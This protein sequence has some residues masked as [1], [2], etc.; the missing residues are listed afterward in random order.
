MQILLCAATEFEVS[1]TKEFIKKNGLENT[2]QLLITGVGMIA[3]TYAITKGVFTT[4]PSIILQAGVA[5]SLTTDYSLGAVAVVGSE[6]IGDAG[7]EEEEKFLSLFD[8]NLLNENS[9]PWQNKR[10]PNKHQPLLEIAALPVVSAVT[11]NEIT[12]NPKKIKYYKTEWEAS[13]ESL[14]GAALHYVAG[15]ENIPFLQLRSVSNFVGERDKR[16]WA[17]DKAI[18]ALNNELQQLILK[19]I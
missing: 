4:K 7:V 19:I 13:L 11:V 6:V 10:L 5:G 3:A 16:K 2:I 12:T 14:E 17:L 15:I 8:L 18:T 9:L 1:H